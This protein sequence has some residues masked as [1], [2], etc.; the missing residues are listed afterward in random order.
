MAG[1]GL[2]Q[3]GAGGEG[4]REGGVPTTAALG[5]TIVRFVPSE[6]NE[7]R[8]RFGTLIDVP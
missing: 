2:D 8:V 5:L 6:L 3:I 7:P 4:I 1:L